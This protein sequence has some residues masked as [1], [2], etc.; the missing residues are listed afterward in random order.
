M[1]AHAIE[2]SNL[3]I[4]HRA[5]PVVLASQEGMFRWGLFEFTQ[6]RLI[7]FKVCERPHPAVEGSDTISPPPREATNWEDSPVPKK[8]IAYDPKSKQYRCYVDIENVLYYVFFRVLKNDANDTDLIFPVFRHA[9]FYDTSGQEQCISSEA[10]K[11]QLR[12][13]IKDKDYLNRPIALVERIQFV[14]VATQEDKAND[15]KDENKFIVQIEKY[16]QA[17]KT[18]LSDYQKLHAFS[19][20]KWA[21][22]ALRHSSAENEYCNAIRRVLR[23]TV[24]A[25][26]AQEELSLETQNNARALR[27]IL[28][29][30]S[31][32]LQRSVC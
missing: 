25:P 27:S 15:G 29:P 31:I 10:I 11:T 13:I 21:L 16:S 7:G 23:G 26:E 22:I 9:M 6:G 2:N 5:G 24:D 14:P 30:S 17:I 19:A 1:R 4:T 28:F 12:E 3:E 20:I 32:D 18:S 8:T